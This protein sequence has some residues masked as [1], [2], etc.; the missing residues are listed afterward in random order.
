MKTPEA[1]VS[2]AFAPERLRYFTQAASSP[3]TG[4]AACIVWRAARQAQRVAGAALQ[5]G[6]SPS[7]LH[8]LFHGTLPL[9]A[10]SLRTLGTVSAYLDL[11]PVV[12]A[13][14]AGYLRDGD[15]DAPDARPAIAP[16]AGE[17]AAW[18]RSGPVVTWRQWARIFGRA[19]ADVAGGL[20]TGTWISV[21]LIPRCRPS[22]PSEY[23]RTWVL[24]TLRQ[25]G[26]DLSV[27]CRALELRPV[28]LR[29][30]LENRV[31]PQLY[32]RAQ[33][34]RFADFLSGP[35]VAV[36]AAIDALEGRHG[37]TQAV[38]KEPPGHPPLQPGQ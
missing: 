8:Q 32:P 11:A 12:L 3:G 26:E 30:F 15:F 10:L 20:D 18:L 9:T 19:D 2:T 38:A 25:R 29:C 22:A 31:D 4:V 1:A 28:E 33:L 21:T 23:L 34:R 24:E 35:G 7:Q 16:Y 14:S 36:L 13:I 5:C 6:L 27:A 17:W 37:C